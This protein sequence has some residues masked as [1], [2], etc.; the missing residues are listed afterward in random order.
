MKKHA[1]FTLIELL[2]TISVMLILLTL[3]TAS[4]TSYQANAR[5]EERKTDVNEIAQQLESYYQTH[6]VYPYTTLMNSES[7]IKSTLPD[8]ESRALRDPNTAITST[9]S[10]TVASSASVPTSAS[11]NSGKIYQYQPLDTTNALC[12]SSAQECLKFN[13]YY[14]LET[15]SSVVT[16]KSRHQ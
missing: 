1:G 9:P 3:V 11:L 8:L 12:T 14:N 7:T 10:L 6:G 2:V 5:D 4:L 13:I 16:I 15:N